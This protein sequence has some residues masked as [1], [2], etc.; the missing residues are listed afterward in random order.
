MVL[1]PGKQVTVFLD[2]W[3]RGKRIFRKPRPLTTSQPLYNGKYPITRGC[4]AAG[5][6]PGMQYFFLL[7]SAYGYSRPGLSGRDIIAQWGYSV[8]NRPQASFLQGNGGRHIRPWPGAF[9]KHQSIIPS[10]YCVSFMT[11]SHRTRVL[12]RRGQRVKVRA[13][14]ERKSYFSLVLRMKSTVPR[15]AMMRVTGRNIVGNSGMGHQLFKEK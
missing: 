9:A 6:S 3:D 8:R 15:N 5:G 11:T 14:E 12:K 13:D 7:I 1:W 10:R 2:V 4:D